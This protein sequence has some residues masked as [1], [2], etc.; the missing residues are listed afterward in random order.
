MDGAGASNA[1]IL[2]LYIIYYLLATAQKQGHQ[3]RSSRSTDFVSSN[4]AENYIQNNGQCQ[5]LHSATLQHQTIEALLSKKYHSLVP[6]YHVTHVDNN[7][8]NDRAFSTEC[9][10]LALASAQRRLTTTSA[11]HPHPS[12]QCQIPGCYQHILQ[13][14]IGLGLRVRITSSIKTRIE[15]EP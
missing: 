13:K 11:V 15:A 5:M 1:S 7:T 8:G 2:L 9:F 6:D 3:I 12:Y 10:K 4:P 14:Q